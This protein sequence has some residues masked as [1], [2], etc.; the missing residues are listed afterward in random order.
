MTIHNLIEDLVLKT[1][2]EIFNEEE[3]DPKHGFCTCQQCRLDVMCYVLNR[4]EP[5]YVVSGRGLAHLLA[6]YK[7]QL[8]TGAD[9]VALVNK[10]IQTVSNTRRPQFA[11]DGNVDVTSPPAG[12]LFNFPVIEGMVLNG[13]NFEPVYDIAVS[14]LTQGDLVPMI[15]ANWQNPYPI[16]ERTAGRFFFWPYPVAALGAGET[17]AF[18]FELA[19]SAPAYDPL[20]HFLRIELSAESAFVGEF[21]YQ[22]A[23]K[24][25]NLVLF[26]LGSDNGNAE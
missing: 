17:R 26:P 18:D 7:D 9:L 8:Q 20:H 16:S 21:H 15:D 23:F 22:R 10:G 12:P 24:V 6:D 3:R 19:V 5:Q 4:V 14:L 11:H 1:V 25:D 2:D 13:A